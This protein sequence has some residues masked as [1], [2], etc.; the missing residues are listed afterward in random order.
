MF[1]YE[2]DSNKNT[3][4]KVGCKT[5]V[6]L[7]AKVA[8]AHVEFDHLGGVLFMIRPACNGQLG[9]WFNEIKECFWDTI[10]TDETRSGGGIDC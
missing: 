8:D 4:W 5:K 3:R 6:I 7:D 9:T 2:E 1:V 10:W